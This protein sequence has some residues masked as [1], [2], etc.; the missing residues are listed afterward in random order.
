MQPE[1]MA[2]AVAKA[3]GV[4]DGAEGPLKDDVELIGGG[5]GGG[6]TD[7]DGVAKGEKG[8]TL[9]AWCKRA[10]IRTY[11]YTFIEITVMKNNQTKGKEASPFYSRGAETCP[12][13]ARPFA[14]SRTLV[15]IH[16]IRPESTWSLRCRR[17]CGGEVA[18]VAAAPTS[19]APV[20][21]WPPCTPR[22]RWPHPPGAPEAAQSEKTAGS[23]SSRS[24]ASA[25][26]I[27]VG[28]PSAWRGNQSTAHRRSP[29][30]RVEDDALH[31][32]VPARRGG[33]RAHRAVVMALLVGGR[34]RRAATAS[35]AVAS[36]APGGQS[37]LHQAISCITGYIHAVELAF[38][39][40]LF[41][42]APAAWVFHVLSMTGLRLSMRPDPPPPPPAPP[43]CGEWW[44]WCGGGG[45][46]WW[47]WTWCGGPRPGW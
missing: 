34:L 39:V 44:R 16:K 46:W 22:S 38:Q 31:H 11:T 17:C 9:S 4:A 8:G 40:S 6:G 28:K 21:P 26:P 2:D 13:T 47:T 36:T 24:L 20:T 27:K 15:K 10:W 1:V 7:G 35:S 23:E 37:R 42:A 41:L 45:G 3:E 33:G 25:R 5:G 19:V 43:L 29:A 30:A 18:A 12:K 32:P 14:R